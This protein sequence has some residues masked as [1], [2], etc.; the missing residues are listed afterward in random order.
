[1]KPWYQSKLVW[2]GVLTTILGIAPLVATY[3]KLISPG[4][5]MIADATVVLVSGIVTV[6]LRVWF[7]D[8]AIQH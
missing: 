8:T 1:M 4:A 7:T 3:V 5:A 2:T 6:I